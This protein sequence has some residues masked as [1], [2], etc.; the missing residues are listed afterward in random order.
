MKEDALAILKEFDKSTK[1]AQEYARKAFEYAIRSR[2]LMAS[3][4]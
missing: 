1:R 2:D 4:H 3:A